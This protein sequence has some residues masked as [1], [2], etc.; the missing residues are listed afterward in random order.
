MPTSTPDQARSRSAS[1]AARLGFPRL[2]SGPAEG[3]PSWLTSG[4]RSEAGSPRPAATSSVTPNPS[5]CTRCTSKCCRA[6]E[7]GAPGLIRSRSIDH[8]HGSCRSTSGAAPAGCASKA[9]ASDAPRRAEADLHNRGGPEHTTPHS[10][11]HEARRH[12]VDGLLQSWPNIATCPLPAAR[13]CSVGGSQQ[14][15]SSPSSPPGVCTS[16]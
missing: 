4:Q 12:A 7:S 5:R 15:W 10:A 3:E 6:A 11:S 9:V 1:R 2:G 8:I 16:R 14:L 13:F